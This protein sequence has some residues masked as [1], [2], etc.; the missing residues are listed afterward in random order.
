Y[1]QY[2]TYISIEFHKFSESAKKFGVD[3]AGVLHY[4]KSEGERF[5]KLISEDKVS[6]TNSFAKID[7]ST[8]S[9]LSPAQ[10]AE[11]IEIGF[12]CGDIHQIL[13]CNVNRSSAYNHIGRKEIPNTIKI[14]IDL[15]DFDPHLANLWLFT[16]R[17]K[18]GG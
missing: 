9:S 12:K 15:N 6:R 14:N 18:D 4:K 2:E 10:Q 3:I 16:Q 1:G 5:D 7:C 13:S 17:L 11:L 8:Y